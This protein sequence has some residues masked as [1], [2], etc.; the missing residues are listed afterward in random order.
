MLCTG[1]KQL[2]SAIDQM[3]MSDVWAMFEH[4]NE[5]PP[6]HVLLRGFTGWKPAKVNAEIDPAAMA[7][8][9]GLFG[10]PQKAPEHVRDLVR[11]AEDIK[12]K[13]G[14]GES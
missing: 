11:W 9:T 4:W 6:E 5:W 10:A 3:L 8:L 12:K 2:P 1:L 13:L 7:E 14:H